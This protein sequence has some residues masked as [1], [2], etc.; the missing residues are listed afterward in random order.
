MGE[1][2]AWQGHAGE[3]VQVMAWEKCISMQ[4]TYFDYC[5]HVH[6]HMDTQKF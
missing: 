1:G 4:V 5:L 2:S 3:E 6:M